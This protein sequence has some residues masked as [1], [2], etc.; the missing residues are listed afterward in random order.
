MRNVIGL[1]GQK[2]SG[3]THFANALAAKRKDTFVC[4]FASP[5]RLLVYSLMYQR[6]NYEVVARSWFDAMGLPDRSRELVRFIESHDNL[7]EFDEYGKPRKALQLIGTEFLRS[8]IPG[9]HLTLLERRVNTRQAN[10]DSCIV[11]DV[12]FDDEVDLILSYNHNV[13]VRIIGAEDELEPEHESERGIDWTKHPVIVFDNRARSEAQL[14][15]FLD[16]LLH[17]M[18]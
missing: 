10:G 1:S 17:N 3:K 12:R 7:F 8:E 16:K 11:D 2:R 5:L 14:D 18:V 13:V 4:S 6:K 15:A 9:C